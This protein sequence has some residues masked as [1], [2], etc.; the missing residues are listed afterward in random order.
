MCGLYFTVAL[1]NVSLFHTEVV[2]Y[3]YD[4]FNWVINFGALEQSWRMAP[5]PPS[6]PW[7]IW[8]PWSF[9][10]WSPSRAPL[11]VLEWCPIHH[12]ALFPPPF[13]LPLFFFPFRFLFLFFCAPLVPGGPIHR[14]RPLLAYPT[15]SRS[16]FSNIEITFMICPYTPP[17]EDTQL[18]HLSD[19]LLNTALAICD[20]IKQKW[21]FIACSAVWACSSVCM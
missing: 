10:P 7:S 9:L 8:R 21:E 14:I 2:K 18:W 1:Y 20:V 17:V 4:K 15:Y 19:T 6:P 3:L 11:L 16:P 13:F 5:S 12:A